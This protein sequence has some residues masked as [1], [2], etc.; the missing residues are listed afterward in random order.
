MQRLQLILCVIAESP[1]NTQSPIASGIL[2]FFPTAS[3]QSAIMSTSNT[4]CKVRIRSDDCAFIIE[5]D[6][7]N[8]AEM[9]VV[10]KVMYKAGVNGAANTTMNFSFAKSAPLAE[11]AAGHKLD[12]VSACNTNL[13]PALVAVVSVDFSPTDRGA[14]KW[15]NSETMWRGPNGTLPRGNEKLDAQ[16]NMTAD[17]FNE[18]ASS[19]KGIK[20]ARPN[21]FKEKIFPA[22]IRLDKGFQVVEVSKDGREREITDPNDMFLQRVIDLAHSPRDGRRPKK[23]N[24]KTPAEGDEKAD[25]E[26]TEA[27]GG[28]KSKGKANKG[29][30]RAN[31]GEGDG[32]GEADKP[33]K[34]LRRSENGAAAEKGGGAKVKKEDGMNS[35]DGG[36]AKK[37]DP[38]AAESIKSLTGTGTPVQPPVGGESDA[39]KLCASSWDSLTDHFT[40]LQD[41]P[42]LEDRSLE[43]YVFKYTGFTLL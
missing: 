14:Y 24:A 30:G 7:Q 38:P 2:A 4:P 41:E 1:D 11:K 5:D 3:S 27:V 20:K 33:R 21:L 10:A 17:E 36:Q 18:L 29:K 28:K 42:G 34:R 26:Q 37:R 8:R 39:G 25:P 43:G 19:E 15:D 32:D 16:S 35:H 22:I 40:V 12:T 6:A 9:Q 13:D 31:A 23:R